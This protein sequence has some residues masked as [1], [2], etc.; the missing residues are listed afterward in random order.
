MDEMGRG[1]QPKIA[2]RFEGQRKILETRTVGPRYGQMTLRRTLTAAS[3]LLG[4]AAELDGKPED[5]KSAY[6][7]TLPPSGAGG[8]GSGAMTTGGMSVGG[9]QTAGMTQTAGATQTGGTGGSVTPALDPCVKE[10]LTTCASVCHSTMNAP[11]LGKADLS[12]DDVGMRLRDKAAAQACGTSTKL[13]DPAAPSESVLLKRTLDAGT[14]GALQVM[15]SPQ[16]PLTAEQ[17]N[18]LAQWLG[19]FR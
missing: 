9:Q 5:Y 12:G 10:I 8:G 1:R 16:T 13:I 3:L 11:L 4:C 19:K 15:P 6:G 14:C 2:L 18:C 17:R 7:G